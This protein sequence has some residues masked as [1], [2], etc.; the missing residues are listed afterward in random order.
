MDL[1]RKH[2]E[3]QLFGPMIRDLAIT[4]VLLA[5]VAACFVRG[6]RFVPDLPNPSRLV[7]VEAVNETLR[8]VCGAWAPA[9]HLVLRVST[10][11]E[12][13]QSGRASRPE[14]PWAGLELGPLFDDYVFPVLKV[15]A[16]GL[17]GRERRIGLWGA[18]ILSVVL[19]PIGGLLVALLSGPPPPPPDAEATRHREARD[20]A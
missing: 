12:S 14:N 20:G 17:L 9:D 7:N 1:T 18:L 15:L 19:T 2:P 5:L 3:K 16:V 4:F 8:D 6:G 10:L 13:S 11:A